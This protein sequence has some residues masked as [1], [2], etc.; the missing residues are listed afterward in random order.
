MWLQA[1][2]VEIIPNLYLGNATISSDETILERHNIKHVLNVTPDLPNLFENSIRYLQI[3]ISD[4]W[5]Q[6]MLNY[7]PAAIAFIGK[8]SLFPLISLFCPLTLE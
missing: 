1:F 2:P 7:F 6:S 4:H 3:P 5:T 8:P